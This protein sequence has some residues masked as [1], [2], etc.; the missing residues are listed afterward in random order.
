M[1]LLHVIHDAAQ[2]ATIEF[3]ISEFD[4]MLFEFRVNLQV[5]KTFIHV[6]IWIIIYKQVTNLFQS[7]YYLNNIIYGFSNYLLRRK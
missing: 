1:P 4:M 3:Y 6:T 7:N 5:L 2:L